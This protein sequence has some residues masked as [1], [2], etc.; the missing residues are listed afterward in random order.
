MKSASAVM[1]VLALGL[2]G[3]MAQPASAASVKITPLGS[4]DG[5]FCIFDRAMVFEDPDGTR[6]LYDAGVTTRGPEDPRLGKI[7]AVLL[8]HVHWDHLGNNH[9]PEANAGA[10]NKPALTVKATPNGNTVNIVVAKKARFLVGGEMNSFFTHKVKA[11]GGDPKLVQALRFGA[12]TK[13]G[14]VAIASVPAVH[15]NGVAPEFLGKELAEQLSTN[16]LTAYVGPPGG[17][18]V[19]FTNGLVVYLSGDTGITA[20]QE[21]VVRRFFKANLAVINIGGVFTTGPAEAAYVI[22]DMV[23]PN[24]VIPSHANEAATKDGKLIP[25]T[26]TETFRKTVKIPTHVPLSGK[27]MEFDGGGKCVAGC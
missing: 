18:V 2:A 24:A 13:V 11:A 20:E 27:T 22:T 6:I 3:M 12:M 26:R 7:D 21:L 15:S 5:E 17:Y 10:C 1:A 16:G 23:K 14:G 19:Q 25:G 9:Q 8:T 4:H